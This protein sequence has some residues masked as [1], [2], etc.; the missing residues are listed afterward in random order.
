VVWCFL[1][2]QTEIRTSKCKAPG[3]PCL[4][5]AGWRQHLNLCPKGKDA[6]EST[7]G[8]P[9]NTI[10]HSRYG[11]SHLIRRRFEHLNAAMPTAGHHIL[12]QQFVCQP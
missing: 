11:A 12:F 4:P 8:S 10:P 9:R 7:G 5:P 3:E 6:A 2:N 1:F